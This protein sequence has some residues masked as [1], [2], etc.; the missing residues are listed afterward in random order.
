MNH[1]KNLF[2]L[3]KP[4][5]G[6]SELLDFM[7]NKISSEERSKIYHIG[8]MKVMDDFVWLWQKFIEDNLWERLIGKRFHSKRSGNLHIVDDASLYDFMIEKLNIEAKKLLKND[9]FYDE[10]TLLIEFARGGEKPYLPAMNRFDSEVL[11]SSVILYVD[12]SAEESRRRNEARYQEKL[13]HSVLSHKCPDEDMERFYQSDDW[14]AIT[15]GKVDGFLK[16]NGVDVPFV[17]MN[18][19]PESKDPVILGPRYK[20][21]LDL[22]YELYQKNTL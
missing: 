9:G 16:L 8:E 10:H 6:K 7:T 20:K 14:A 18:N 5:C 19:E 13:K 12:V 17:T 21:A 3:G 1:F 22:L 2:V 15:G 11:K 4:A